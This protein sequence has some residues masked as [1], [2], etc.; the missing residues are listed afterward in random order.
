MIERTSLRAL[1]GV[2]VEGDRYANGCGYW[3]F[4]A[5]F[6]DEITFVEIEAIE[7][8]RAAL[9]LPFAARQSRRNV[10]T[11][12]I[13]LEAMIGKHFAIGD[14]IFTG[15]RPCDPCAYLDRLLGIPVRAKLTGRGGLRAS[16]VRS[17]TIRLGAAIECPER[18]EDASIRG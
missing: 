10:V 8:V 4:D 7:D 15:L 12:G 18:D 9:G 11:R 14:A 2:G 6:V 1:A 13:A 17:G 3:S 5:K 16:I